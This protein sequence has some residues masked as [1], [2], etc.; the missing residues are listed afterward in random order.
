M[1]CHLAGTRIGSHD[2]IFRAGHP[3]LVSVDSASTLLLPANPLSRS[4]SRPL[5]LVFSL[6]PTLATAGSRERSDV[7]P[8]P[9]KESIRFVG[10]P[11]SVVI[12]PWSTVRCSSQA[13]PQSPCPVPSST[14]SF[15][16][17]TLSE[18]RLVAGPLCFVCCQWIEKP[19]TSIPSCCRSSR[20]NGLGG[21]LWSVEGAAWSMTP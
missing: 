5:V 12:G 21:I 16:L 8:E 3:V 14:V 4:F 7:K 20:D 13:R 9:L 10:C 11:L 15:P 2:E 1:R 17:S 19:A 6:R 18:A